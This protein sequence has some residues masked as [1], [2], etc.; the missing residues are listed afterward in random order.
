MS[1]LFTKFKLRQVISI[2]S[3]YIWISAC[4]E[5]TTFDPKIP[6]EIACADCGKHVSQRDKECGACA[7]LVTDSIQVFKESKKQEIKKQQEIEHALKKL[8]QEKMSLLALEAQKAESLREA[9]A[10]ELS[11]EKEIRAQQDSRYREAQKLQEVREIENKIRI[12]NQKESTKKEYEEKVLREKRYWDNLKSVPRGFNIRLVPGSQDQILFREIFKNYLKQN[13]AKDLHE[14][15]E[16]ELKRS[17]TE[18]IENIKDLA[19][20]VTVKVK[21][22]IIKCSCSNGKII[23]ETSGLKREIVT[24]KRCAGTGHKIGVINYKLFYSEYK[25]GGV[26]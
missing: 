18:F 16:M 6:L 7:F 9:N 14:F 23:L 24:C 22:S 25:K 13:F 15:S 17:Q 26:Q 5:D 1:Y 11:K 20:S 12:E 10:R 4:S 19:N 2:V 3:F 21:D 8:E